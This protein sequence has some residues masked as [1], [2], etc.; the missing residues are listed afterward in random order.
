MS[1]AGE[2]SSFAPEPP[3]AV[4]PTVVWYGARVQWSGWSWHERWT[5]SELSWIG[6]KSEHFFKNYR[7]VFFTGF[8][9]LMIGMISYSLF[10]L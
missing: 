10:L 2:W 1:V 6:E 7:V 8:W 9:W 3:A 4:Q 5:E